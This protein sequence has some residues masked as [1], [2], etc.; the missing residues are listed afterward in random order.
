M[1]EVESANSEFVNSIHRTPVAT[2]GIGYIDVSNVYTGATVTLFSFSDGTKV[3]DTPTN[4]GDGT[5]RSR[6]VVSGIGN[7]NYNPDTA[8]TRA[9]FAAMVVR[10]LGLEPGIG[11]ESFTDIN[12]AEWFKPYVETANQY[13]IITGYNEKTF[14]PNDKITR[15]QA[16]A[17]IARAMKLTGIE[18]ELTNQEMNSIMG[19]FADAQT[20]ANYAKKSLA[21][22]LKTGIISGTG[23]GYLSQK[24]M[25][26]GQ[27][28]PSF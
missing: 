10:A 12:S 19:D 7:G 28:L 22:C 17:M 11:K 5:V 3:S 24:T 2:A 15:E 16:I 23:N 26:Q 21:L 27:K 6:L 13:G 20:V 4:N 9:E 1:D 8:I 25:S 14:A 18:Q